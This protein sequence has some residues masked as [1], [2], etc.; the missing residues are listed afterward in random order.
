MVS[1]PARRD[2]GLLEQTF[3]KV[4]KRDSNVEGKDRFDGLPVRHYVM[5][6]LL[7]EMFGP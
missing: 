6:V 2:W 3:Y 4:D 1:H 7:S 5:L